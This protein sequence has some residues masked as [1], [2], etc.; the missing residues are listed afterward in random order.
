MK[1]MPLWIIEREFSGS[2]REIVQVTYD[3]DL[4]GTIIQAD[5][6]RWTMPVSY[7]ISTHYPAISSNGIITT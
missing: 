4:I 7:H 2:S 3:A 1:T 5:I 6:T